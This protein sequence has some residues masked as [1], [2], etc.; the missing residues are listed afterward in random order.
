[1][2]TAGFLPPGVDD[3]AAARAAAAHGVEVTP[4]SR[5]A[6]RTMARGGLQL[7]FAPVE[8]REIR[9]GVRDLARAL[10]TLTSGRQ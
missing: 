5:Y 3:Q 8:P 2:Q 4:L 6:R 7:G 10:A 1:L 9:R